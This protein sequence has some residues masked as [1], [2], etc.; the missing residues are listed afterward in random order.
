MER[1]GVPVAHILSDGTL[2]P[3]SRT[4]ARLVLDMKL[5]E[6]DLFRTEQELIEEA[7]DARAEKVAYVRP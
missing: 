6:T 5:G 2:E 7:Y 4:M 3:N 1:S